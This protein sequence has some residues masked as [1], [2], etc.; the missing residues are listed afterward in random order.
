MDAK[1]YWYTWQGKEM[2]DQNAKETFNLE[3]T[4]ST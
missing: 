1:S 2:G 3:C 4:T